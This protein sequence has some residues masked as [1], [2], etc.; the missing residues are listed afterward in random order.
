MT[1]VKTFSPRTMP[2]GAAFDDE[3]IDE[4]VRGSIRNGEPVAWSWP[5]GG[6][7]LRMRSPR[8][9]HKLN[10]VMRCGSAFVLLHSDVAQELEKEPFVERLPVT[11]LGGGGAEVSRDYVLL[12]VL[13][14]ACLNDADTV[15]VR[16]ELD[17][18]FDAIT[19]FA[20]DLDA[21]GDA[22]VFRVKGFN[23]SVTFVRGDLL[24]KLEA[25]DSAYIGTLDELED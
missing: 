2:S 9:S 8:S 12:N 7:G 14:V 4:D 13:K 25:I 16:N 20:F 21:L 23:P 17:G 11:L 1:D 19:E 15:G 24:E 18:T 6:V 5:K 10:P 3:T 22:C